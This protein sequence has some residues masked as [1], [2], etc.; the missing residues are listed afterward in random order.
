MRA[1]AFPFLKFV[2]A[3]FAK[4][5][6][7]LLSLFLAFTKLST[8]FR[9]G[10]FIARVVECYIIYSPVISTTHIA[11]YGAQFREW[12][13]VAQTKKDQ[14]DNFEFARP[15]PICKIVD[16]YINGESSLAVCKR[17]LIPTDGMARVQD[18]VD[19]QETVDSRE[20]KALWVFGY[21]SLC[22]RPGFQFD[23]AVV[24]NICGYARK[25]W[26]GN[27]THRGT[28]EK[29]NTEL[30]DGLNSAHG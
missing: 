25:F 15:V 13:C 19:L 5:E 11:L 23:K 12:T 6:T 3:S 30:K 9:E 28:K 24:G 20:S 2:Y 27:N 8:C 14:H 4:N 22:W 18:V 26:Q 1:H 10:R 21:G 29:V 7:I 17:K 16:I